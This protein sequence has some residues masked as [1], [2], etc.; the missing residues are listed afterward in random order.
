M[1]SESKLYMPHENCIRRMPVSGEYRGYDY[2]QSSRA[3]LYL[4]QA[5]A[6][7]GTWKYLPEHLMLLRANMDR[8]SGQASERK[9][10]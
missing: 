3:A 5:A 6:Q 9:S 1:M 8:H 2:E 7:S 10:T 4:I